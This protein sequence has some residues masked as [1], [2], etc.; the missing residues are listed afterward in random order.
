MENRIICITITH[1]MGTHSQHLI[2]P[3]SVD[4][5]SPFEVNKHLSF[6]L[7]TMRELFDDVTNTGYY[8]VTDRYIIQKVL[9]QKINDN[10]AEILKIEQDSYAYKYALE[11]LK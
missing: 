4:L 8:K 11:K 2:I 7:K 1:S 10:N 3:K 6:K 9:Q 5:G